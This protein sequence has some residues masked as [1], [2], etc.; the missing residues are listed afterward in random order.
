VDSNL[1]AGGG[2]L[3]LRAIYQLPLCVSLVFLVVQVLRA[4]ASEALAYVI[5]HTEESPE[6]W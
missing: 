5:R 1:L 2:H 4:S 3:A 6:R